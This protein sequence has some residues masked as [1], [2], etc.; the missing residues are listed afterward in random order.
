MPCHGR[1]ESGH[2]RPRH[3]FYEAIGLPAEVRFKSAPEAAPGAQQ[4][5]VSIATSPDRDAPSASKL[6]E[7]RRKTVLY[8]VH[9]WRQLCR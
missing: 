1:S 9:A 7:Q 5:P 8:P 3:A 2:S 4:A 6:R